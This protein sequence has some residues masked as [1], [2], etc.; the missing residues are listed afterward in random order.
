MARSPTGEKEADMKKEIKIGI[1]LAG[2]LVILGAFIFVVGD[3]TE[4]FKKPGYTLNVLTSSALGLESRSSVKMA[5]I[6]I[7]YIK[8]IVLSDRKA[9]VVMNIYPQH[10]VPLGSKATL[11]SLGLLG[12]RFMEIVPGA[13]PGFFESGATLEGLP[14]VTFDQM[15]A[16]FISLGDEVKQIGD[17]VRGL[18]SKDMS[19]DLH[20][21]LENLSRLTAELSAFVSA[22]KDGIGQTF[23]DASRTVQDVGGQFREVSENLNKTVSGY[24]ALA[25]DNRDNLRANMEKIRDVLAKVEQAVDRLNES[26]EKVRKSEGTLG[27]LVNDRELYDKVEGAVGDIRKISGAA[28]SL[29]AD[30]EL[31]GDY[32]GDSRLAKGSLSLG[33]LA[34]GKT[35]LSGGIT[36]DPWDDRFVYS[37]QGGRRWGGFVP[38]AGIIESEFGAGL[39]YYLLRDRMALGIEG[40]DF[41][42]TPRPR[43]RAFGKYYPVKNLFFVVGVDDFTLAPKREF[44]FGLGVGL[45]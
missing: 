17:S 31:R 19:T 28:S 4:L 39:D 8:D 9:K 13:G 36:H 20:Q 12:E 32:Y 33:I 42:R 15:G 5:G 38:R 14:S 18:L 6:K 26:L 1:F 7:G 16:L 25:A 3:M 24:G 43:F 40:F 45:R 22:N 11:A 21:S 41:N 34:G 23:R 27:K 2:A 44:F 30:I 10:Q 35:Y 37:L 29:R